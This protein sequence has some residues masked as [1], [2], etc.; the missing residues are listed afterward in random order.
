M[1]N[2]EYLGFIEDGGYRTARAVAL[3]RLGA[4]VQ[5]RGWTAPLYW[6]QIDGRWWRMTLAGM[7]PRRAG[8]AGLPRELLRG[9]RLRP[10]GRRAPA[11]R[12]RVGARRRASAPSAGNFVESGR[13][14]PAPAHGRRRRAGAALR[15]RLGVDRA[16]PTSPYPG[17]RPAEG[18]VGEYNG[19]FMCNQFVLRGGSCATPAVPH[20]ADLPELLPA[21][22]PLAVQRDPSCGRRVRS[23]RRKARAPAPR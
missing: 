8:R 4:R 20:P 2:G 13:F 23:I 22:C 19:K 18:A 12:G 16:A 15:R 3:R 11:D 14:H 5:E 7:R 9:G 6:E 17:F 21:R 1:T 10:L